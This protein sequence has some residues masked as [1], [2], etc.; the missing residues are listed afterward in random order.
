MVA[1]P[2]SVEGSG[3]HWSLLLPVLKRIEAKGLLELVFVSSLPSSVANNIR[4]RL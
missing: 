4:L 3:A 2:V 1:V